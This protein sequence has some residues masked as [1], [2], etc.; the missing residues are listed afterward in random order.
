M[1]DMVGGMI[2]PG[3]LRLCSQ[4]LF[5]YDRMHTLCTFSWFCLFELLSQQPSL[6]RL[7]DGR[8]IGYK[9]AVR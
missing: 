9:N 3:E 4:H 8:Q 1:I 2:G 7:V 6:L 5:D